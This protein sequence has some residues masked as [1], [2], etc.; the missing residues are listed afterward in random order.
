MS[1][2][3]LIADEMHE[4]LFPLLKETGIA[5][6]F[7]PQISRNEIKEKLHAYDGLI[8]RSKTRVDAELLADADKLKVVC[9]A[10]AGIDNLDEDILRERN[11]YIINAPEGNRDAVAE[12][13]IGMLLNLFTRICLADRQV[14]DHIWD[15]EGNRGI[16][17]KGKTVGII[18][19]GNMGSAFAERLR[20]FGC[21]ILAYDRYRKEIGDKQ[22]KEASLE[23]IFEQV[24]V[25]SL[26]IP[27]T[28]ETKGWINSEF[29]SNFRKN[30]FMLNTS[31][32]EVLP[33]KDLVEA[34]KSG[35]VKG[36]ALD[37]LENEKLDKLS[38]EQYS[39]FQFLT[40]SENVLLT[41]HVAGWTIESYR[42]INEVLI[43]KLKKW[44]DKGL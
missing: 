13:C 35:K 21:K 25:L 26:H 34:L 41:P 17:L 44:I 6:D 2:N 1:L 38:K 4:S 18:G 3:F 22:V 23:E 15:R 10:G 29:I 12:Q 37:V 8:I 30:I 42:R 9:R 16:E 28:N 27:L 39:Y 5:F 20:S 11:I 7:K 32:G 33:F 31:R 36:A 40:S 24:D 43:E 14:R 19:Y